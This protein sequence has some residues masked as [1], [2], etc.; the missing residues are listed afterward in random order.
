MGDTV[1]V[2][3]VN[4]NNKTEI[5]KAM[6]DGRMYAVTGT[7]KPALDLFQIWD[8]KENHWVEMGDTATVT[9]ST[10]LKIKV[11][12]P[13]ERK[14]QMKLKLVREGIVIREID[15]GT[16][17]DVEHVD[18]YF[19]LGGKTYYRIDIDGK[20]ISNPIYVKMQGKGS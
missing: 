16:G 7:S 13:D 5:L 8:E 20:L 10:R 12:L 17:L 9:G 1:T 18:E 11:S 2:F 3:L 6:R 4:A 15:L 14:G 19:K